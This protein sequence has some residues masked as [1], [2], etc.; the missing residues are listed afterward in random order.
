MNY[1]IGNTK[2]ANKEPEAI[3]LTLEIELDDHRI[4]QHS[5]LNAYV[6]LPL[7]EFYDRPTDIYEIKPVIASGYR[8]CNLC[9]VAVHQMEMYL[10]V[11]SYGSLLNWENL[12][13]KL[14]LSILQI[15]SLRKCVSPML[16]LLELHSNL[17]L[18]IIID[19]ICE[20]NRVDLLISLIPYLPKNNLT[21][22]QISLDSGICNNSNNN[23]SF[24]QNER[25]HSDHLFTSRRSKQLVDILV[26][27]ILVMHH[28]NEL[29]I[30]LKKNFNW[31]MKN[32]KKQAS[33][34]GT[35]IFDVNDYLCGEGS[36]VDLIEIFKQATHIISVLSED[37]SKILNSDGDQQNA[38]KKYI[39][40][41]M[42][43]EYIQDGSINKRFRAVMLQG[44]DRAV[45]PIGWSRNTVIYE[46]PANHAQ[47]FKKLFG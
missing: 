12:A 20:L 31:F 42:N 29:N 39:N 8:I 6:S 41:L 35:F 1:T 22:D 11:P 32:L 7:E 4:I 44:T 27:S 9:A 16:K 38:V 43:T 47:L 28:E 40:N 13:A 3:S 25:F 33:G 46:F 30:N 18:N 19:A 14:G 23:N 36:M 34:K 5:A 15:L 21:S 24:L 37:Y 10:N 2:S 45:L 17:P 26:K